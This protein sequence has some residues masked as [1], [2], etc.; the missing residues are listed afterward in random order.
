MAGVFLGLNVLSGHMKVVLHLTYP[1]NLIHFSNVV[2]DNTRMW[3]MLS[4]PTMPTICL[5]L[6]SD[7]FQSCTVTPL[8]SSASQSDCSK[9][10]HGTGNRVMN[11][12]IW[13]CI[14]RG[15]V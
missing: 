6:S 4:L 11:G 13:Y 12:Y 5:E 1:S 2:K 8:I 14:I 9:G 3:H 15:I 7:N 10:V